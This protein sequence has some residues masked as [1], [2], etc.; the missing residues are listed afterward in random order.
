M[1]PSQTFHVRETRMSYISPFNAV[2]P[3]GRETQGEDGFYLEHMRY[4]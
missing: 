2:G 1:G 3:K 4:A